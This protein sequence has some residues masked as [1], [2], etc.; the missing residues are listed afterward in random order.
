[1]IGFGALLPGYQVAE[2]DIDAPKG[3]MDFMENMGHRLKSTF[4]NNPLQAAGRW[5]ERSNYA[6]GADWAI[7]AGLNKAMTEDEWKKS[8]FFR[9]EGLYGG[10][11]LKYQPNMTPQYAKVL[12]E[13][14]DTSHYYDY[15]AGQRSGIFTGISGF[16]A[17]APA[18]MADPTAWMV[19]AGVFEG[20]AAKT[21]YGRLAGAGVTAEKLAE[22]EAANTGLI[23]SMARKAGAVAAP[24]LA[25][26]PFAYIDKPDE[27]GIDTFVANMGSAI[28]LGSGIGAFGYAWR[29]ATGFPE[30]V[31]ATR[32]AMLD[33]IN[34]K[35]VDTYDYVASPYSALNTFNL[36]KARTMFQ[37]IEAENAKAE[38][39]RVGGEEFYT[40]ERAAGAQAEI[41]IQK[42]KLD[43]IISSAGEWSDRSILDRY[44]DEI[45]TQTR[46][47]R[48]HEERLE[49][50]K[51][52]VSDLN[53]K[54]VKAEEIRTAYQK[55]LSQRAEYEKLAPF[56]QVAVRQGVPELQHESYEADLA[57]ANEKFERASQRAEVYQKIVAQ[58]KA[59]LDD[60][61]AGLSKAQ[62]GE[63][64]NGSVV[65]LPEQKA[66]PFDKT[67]VPGLKET[68]I[69]Q[70]AT[71]ERAKIIDEVQQAKERL[72]ATQAQMESITGEQKAPKPGAEATEAM[73]PEVKKVADEHAAIANEY[74]AHGQANGKNVESEIAASNER[75]K[76]ETMLGKVR[77]M[78][79]NCLRG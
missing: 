5:W 71:T 36:L 22:M 9:E 58:S 27:Y 61:N 32:K 23:T 53:E 16:V 57:S 75:I 44:N 2:A 20:A 59:N 48:E 3:D 79:D 46:Y 55:E 24:T 39:E 30:K 40:K 6:A 34:D 42:A 25:A 10:P 60:L 14:Y 38:F 72:K 29:R 78:A 21:M 51:K 28:A 33:I 65:V 66:I 17:S 15:H 63:G 31:A 70:K 73:I 4:E 64:L 26:Q 35:P 52:E 45:Q 1:M 74:A 12:A 76:K 62:F 19:P 50:I 8:A 68:F 69:D 13:Q 11:G 7:K 54:R 49:D 43:A 18:M 67:D 77:T 56:Q 37:R 47:L 41:D